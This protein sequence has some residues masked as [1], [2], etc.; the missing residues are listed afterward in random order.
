MPLASRDV[1]CFL[2]RSEYDSYH[3]SLLPCSIPKYCFSCC[4]LS[5]LNVLWLIREEDH[6]HDLCS[7]HPI[8]CDLLK[9]MSGFLNHRVVN[10]LLTTE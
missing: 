3:F 9:L 5:P 1:G 7:F 4:V 6:G 10:S 8:F 2:M